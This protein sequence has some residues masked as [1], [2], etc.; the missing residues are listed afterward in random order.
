MFLKITKFGLLG[1][2]AFAVS[3]CILMPP[4]T[5]QSTTAIPT[6]AFQAPATP[7]VSTSPA[8]RVQPVNAPNP[9]RFIGDED[10][11]DNDSDD[12]DDDED[13]D[14]GWG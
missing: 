12:D 1:C 3:G 14:E 6:S 10:D 2:A 9:S 11:N 13:E 7:S 4:Q 8:P 5:S